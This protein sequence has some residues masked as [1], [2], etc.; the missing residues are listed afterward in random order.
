MF[1]EHSSP[2]PSDWF[3]KDLSQSS[4]GKAGLPGRARNSGKQAGMGDSQPDTEE[5]TGAG[6]DGEVR[7]HVADVD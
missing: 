2:S 4:R 7:G 6:T 3:N 5:E 1:R